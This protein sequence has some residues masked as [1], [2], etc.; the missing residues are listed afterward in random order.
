MNWEMGM[1]IVAICC[2][3][4]GCFVVKITHTGKRISVIIFGSYFFSYLFY[5]VLAMIE[6]KTSEHESWASIFIIPWAIVGMISMFL[7][8]MI[9]KKRINK[10]NNG[11]Q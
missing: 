4:I 11:I 6:G 3:I 5:W 2:F 9:F 8:Y 10:N 7:G 1:L